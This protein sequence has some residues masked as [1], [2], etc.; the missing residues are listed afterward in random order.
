MKNKRFLKIHDIET[1]IELCEEIELPEYVEEFVGLTPYAVGFRYAMEEISDLPDWYKKVS[2]F[3][4]FVEDKL[5][6]AK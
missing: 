1:L 2:E 3:K 6:R 4:A 5:S